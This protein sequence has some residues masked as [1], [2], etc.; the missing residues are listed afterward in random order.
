MHLHVKQSHSFC[1]YSLGRGGLVTLL[2]I[3]S[4]NMLVKLI[5]FLYVICTCCNG[6]QNIGKQRNMSG[7]KR[8][9]IAFLW[10]RHLNGHSVPVAL[11]IGTEKAKQI[12]PGYAIDYT[13]NDSKCNPK[14]GVK[15]VLNL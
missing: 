11:K 8:L 3:S 5:L 4:T 12:L 2:L 9:N 1:I 14:I 6:D 7:V 13:M 15:A 10:Q